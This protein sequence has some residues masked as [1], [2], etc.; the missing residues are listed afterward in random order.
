M[1]S[2]RETSIHIETPED[3]D[4]SPTISDPEDSPWKPNP[5]QWAVGG[6]NVYQPVPST[7]KVLPPGMYE[8]AVSE[9]G[10]IYHKR[11]I[12]TDELLLFPGG[13][14][15]NILSEITSFWEKREDF[16]KY[17]FLQRR[18][19]LFYGPP[20]SGKTSLTQQILQGVIKTGGIVFVCHDPRPFSRGLQAFRQIEPER[21]VVC[22][23]E[24]LDAIVTTRDNEE[25][26][27]SILDGEDQI[28]RVLNIATTN[29]PEELDK[30]FAARPR[31]FDRKI[32]VDLPD[33]ALRRFYFT[34]KLKLDSD[35]ENW[36][37][38][39]DGFSFAACSELVISVKCL[40]NDFKES[41]ETIRQLLT[42][43]VSSTDYNGGAENIHRLFK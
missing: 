5:T 16:V 21:P 30:R 39:T 4:V 22:L 43:K 7:V 40:G 42:A 10:L 8:I 23:F 9:Q 37:K 13:L 25:Q 26:M 33:A 17:G 24:D 34:H 19:Y 14:S 1:R 38:E 11:S 6:L 35:V 41:V 20:G 15:S 32:K 27:L 12:N 28:D 29:Y 3:P 31:R 18:G 36:V 2:S